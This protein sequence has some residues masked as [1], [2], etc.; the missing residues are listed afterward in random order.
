MAWIKCRKCDR[1]VSDKKRKCPRCGALINQKEVVIDYVNILKKTVFVV[2]EILLMGFV[3]IVSKEV[4]YSGEV[5][6]L[7]ILFLSIIL[8]LTITLINTKKILKELKG[9]YYILVLSVIVGSYGIICGYG[10]KGIM[11]F[12]YDNSL[13]IYNMTD[14]FS[15][16]VAKEIKYEIDKIFEIDEGIS[17]RNVTIGNFYKDN[18]EFILYLDDFYGNYRLKFHI[19]IKENKINDIYWLF[20]EYKLYLVKDGKRSDNFSYYYA[21]Y[22]VDNMMGENVTG[23]ARVED[24]VEKKLKKKFDNYANTIISYDEFIYDEGND[25]FKYKCVAQ[26]MDYYADIDDE[27][28]TI[29]FE[30]LSKAKKK[31]VWY[32]GDASFDYVDLE[33][34]F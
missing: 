10:Y 11:A 18:D 14:R 21:M 7:I 2:F 30:K 5:E 26:N 12:Q 23:L 19:V 27:H 6:P 28:F 22:I 3:F 33:I 4:L 17:V 31:K 9:I 29:Y 32:Y 16:K 34:K 13:E 20:D 8:L 1:R 24:D 15:L 25:T